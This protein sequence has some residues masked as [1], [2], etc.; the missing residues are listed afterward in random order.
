[1]IIKVLKQKSKVLKKEL[2]ALRKQKPDQYSEAF[3]HNVYHYCLNENNFRNL[4]EADYRQSLRQRIQTDENLIKII[5]QVHKAK[6]KEGKSQKHNIEEL[7]EL[8]QCYIQ[9]ADIPYINEFLYWINMSSSSFHDLCSKNVE[10]L[11]LKTKLLDKKSFKIEKRAH[12]GLMPSRIAVQTLR[13]Q[14]MG[15]DVKIEDI[16]NSFNTL[17][18]LMEPFVNNNEKEKD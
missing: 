9:D 10:L 15:Y 4:L 7:A 18:D 6:I 5:N 2:N 16:K 12:Q 13:Q 17:A 11:E 8:L 14:G 3:L 1:M